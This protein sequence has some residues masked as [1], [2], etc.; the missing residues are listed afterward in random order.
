MYITD[1]KLFRLFTY[2]TNTMCTCQI[3]C[4]HADDNCVLCDMF[5]YP[6]EGLAGAVRRGKTEVYYI[7]IYIYKEE[8]VGEN[9]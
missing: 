7:Y 5:V 2:D 4:V 1:I 3:P 8:G 9:R 6:E